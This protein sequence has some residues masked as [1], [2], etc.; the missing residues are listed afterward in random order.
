[1][2]RIPAYRPFALLFA[3]TLAL[4]SALP[5]EAE[6]R[7]KGTA[8]FGLN[9][10]N[11]AISEEYRTR[12]DFH[13]KG[14]ADGGLS[15]G[16]FTRVSIDGQATGNFSGAAVWIKKDKIKLTLGNTS[17]AIAARASIW[18][19]SV[20]YRGASCADLVTNLQPAGW[21]PTMT[22]SSSTG[23]GP[24]LIRLDFPIAKKVKMSISG[25]NGND[26]EIAARWSGKPW[27]VGLGYDFGVET[28][29][30]VTLIIDWKKGKWAVGF[31]LGHYGGITNAVFS[32]AWK[33]RKGHELYAYASVL[34]GAHSVGISWKRDLGG[35]AL[36]KAGLESAAGNI[37]ADVGLKFRF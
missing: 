23:A 13:L 12:V 16:A 17:G 10:K 7:L 2:K 20:G 27:S 26:L 4:L 15:F 33:Y 1:M 32:A 36:I 3:L 25:G 31:D 6:I 5:A 24:N 21:S 29:G 8:R 37:M 19:C 11:G 9:Y 28:H 22:T 18:G 30:G 14:K 35:G 34:A